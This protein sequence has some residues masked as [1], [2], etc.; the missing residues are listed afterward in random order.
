MHRHAR[1]MASHNLGIMWGAKLVG[2][3][4]GALRQ[5]LAAA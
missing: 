2:V 3:T 5:L 4:A 1:A